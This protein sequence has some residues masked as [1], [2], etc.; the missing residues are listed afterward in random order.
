VP[1]AVGAARTGP[2]AVSDP[3]RRL[4]D[5]AGLAGLVVA[6]LSVVSAVAAG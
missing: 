5:A 4:M 2:V 1:V 6:V 3:R